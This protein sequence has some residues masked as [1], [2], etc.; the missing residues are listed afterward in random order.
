MRL[1]LRASP[2]AAPGVQTEHL[3]QQRIR[4]LPIIDKPEKAYI[5][6]IGLETNCGSAV[7][8]Q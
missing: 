8:L 4:K 2:Q 6:F 1:K 7:V 3:R 5:S